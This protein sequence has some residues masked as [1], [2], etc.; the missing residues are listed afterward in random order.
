MSTPLD[1]FAPHCQ[2]LKE[3]LERAL[4]S[5]R[6]GRA[7]PALIEHIMIAAY[8]SSMKLMELGSI[9]APDPRTLV[10]DP[11]DKSIVKDIERGL[12]GANTG[13]SI[14]VDK[15]LIRVTVP[16]LTAETRSAMKKQVSKELEKAKVT[17]RGIRDEMRSVFQAQEKEKTI[18]ED[19]KFRQLERLDK[20]VKKWQEE[21][22]KVGEK[23][24]KELE[25]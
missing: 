9:S 15:D 23:K 16:T 2:K 4:A 1:S 6:T 10:V 19:E 12:T 25:F 24:M 5:I 3:H 13:F 11:W 18:S 17:L 8:G 21:F 7:S 20:E 14:A 22:E